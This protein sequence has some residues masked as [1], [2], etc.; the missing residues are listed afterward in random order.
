MVSSM[1]KERRKQGQRFPQGYIKN[2]ILLIACQHFP[3]GIEE[4]ILRDSL[5]EEFGI[6]EP[7]GIKIHLADLEEKGLLCKFSQKG[8]SNIWKI[9]TEPIFVKVLG[10]DSIPEFI[11]YAGRFL[12][13]ED[14][15]RFL[16]SGYARKMLT[17]DR[18]NQL[19]MSF[20]KSYKEQF[21]TIVDAYKN[22]EKEFTN[23]SGPSLS[24]KIKKSSTILSF[25]LFP[26]RTVA[27]M[28]KEFTEQ[29][30]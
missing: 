7:K 17:E 30:I 25:L 19:A 14:R 16:K 12:F 5:R 13:S 8:K 15:D 28:A 26:E 6:R 10:R 18:I 23:P 1:I 21:K 2:Q 22:L 20:W 11:S 24:K 4:P 27:S 29:V 9:P 3:K